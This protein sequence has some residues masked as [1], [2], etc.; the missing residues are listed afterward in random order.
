MNNLTIL[1]FKTIFLILTFQETFALGNKRC[2]ANFQDRPAIYQMF[3]QLKE[4]VTDRVIMSFNNI[5][6]VGEKAFG[7][8]DEWNPVFSYKGGN[9]YSLNLYYYSEFVSLLR[10]LFHFHSKGLIVTNTLLEARNIQRVL[11][12]EFKNMNFATY[13]RGQSLIR[14][15]QIL[16]DSYT[17]ESHYIITV[18]EW[19]MRARDLSYLSAYINMNVNTPIIERMRDIP[20]FLIPHQGK[21][22]E[23]LLLVNGV[24]NE[25]DEAKD[26]LRL[27]NI[28]KGMS[29]RRQRLKNAT[30]KKGHNIRQKLSM[31][32][33]SLKKS[34]TPNPLSKREFVEIDR[35][36]RT[37]VW[38]LEGKWMNYDDAKSFIQQFNLQNSWK[39]FDKW[40]D[41]DARPENFPK[42][43]DMVYTRTDEWEGWATFLGYEQV[44]WMSYKEAYA[45]ILKVDLPNQEAFDR[46]AKSKERPINFPSHPDR[47]YG[48]QFPG[49][50]QFL[51]NEFMGYQEAKAFI[52]KFNLKGYRDFLRWK[53]RIK[54]IPKNF[55]KNPYK[56][57]LRTGEWEG[58]PVFLGYAT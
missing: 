43:P 41:T 48:N 15:R 20:R 37:F 54:R 7:T 29:F 52:H 31:L 30:G 23:I 56:A 38:A 34:L 45:Y 27:I 11:K 25:K 8:L 2:E 6:V 42:S 4:D 28:A 33:D 58:W 40:K 9:T 32:G 16:E 36:S 44:G 53:K 14:H 17:K 46:W 13:H 3:S 21:Q 26:L 35:E 5:F 39:D 18:R 12:Q 22:A 47:V 10:P 51:G 1:R 55:P 24:Q 49:Y 50:K 19:P 57:Y